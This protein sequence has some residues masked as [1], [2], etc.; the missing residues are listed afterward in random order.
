M[1]KLSF[2]YLLLF[3]IPVLLPGQ[4]INTSLTYSVS[5]PS[6][7]TGKTPVLILLHGY[8][9]NEADLFELAKTMDPK[10]ITFSLR[11]P[12]PSREGGFC[13]YELEFLPDRQFKYDYQKAQESRQ[14]ILSFISNA[15]KAYQLDS[16]Q[17]F[18]LGFSQ[19][20]I[21]AYDIA[22][23]VPGKVKGIV[24]LSGRM[25][26]ESKLRKTDPRQLARVKFFIGHGNSDNVI[27]PEEAVKAEAFLKEKQVTELTYK[28]YEMP[29][30]ISGQELNDLR[31]W[32]TKALLPPEKKPEPKK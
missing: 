27:K 23:N 29:H 26:E 12:N 25:M 21:M 17:V 30:A 16:T 3:F 5:Q 9:S 1:N 7:K 31:A 14:K 24:A 15:C 11:A 13:W 28:S 10:F 20:A 32:L 22:L 8:G 4:T 2:A 18:L 6:K 19:G